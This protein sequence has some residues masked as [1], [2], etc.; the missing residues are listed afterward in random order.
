MFPDVD[1]IAAGDSNTV[2]R[3]Q[4]GRVCS[5][6]IGAKHHYLRGSVD[7]LSVSSPRLL[8]RNDAPSMFIGQQIVSIDMV[9]LLMSFA[10]LPMCHPQHLLSGIRMSPQ[11]FCGVFS[12][13]RRALTNFLQFE[14]HGVSLKEIQW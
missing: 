2:V 11:R 10:A 14:I 3:Q 4:L 5:L 13:Q 12:P 1:P 6:H 8:E 7:Q 9:S